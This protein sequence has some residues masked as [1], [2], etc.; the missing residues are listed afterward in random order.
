MPVDVGLPIRKIDEQ[1]F[2]RID[3]RVTGEAFKIH[4]ELGRF[5]NEKNCQ[6]ALH[7]RVME[8]DLSFAR[9]VRI[10]VSLEDFSKDYFLDFLINHAVVV[11]TKVVANVSNKH[12]AQVLN[13]LYLCDVQ[14][15]TL[16]SFGSEKVEHQFVSTSLTTAKR[17]LAMLSKAAFRP[18]SARCSELPDWVRRMISEWGA[19]LDTNLYKD[20]LTHFFGG[21]KRVCQTVD[22]ELDGK[23]IGS[24]PVRLIADGI[25]VSVTSSVHQPEIVREH[26]RRF[27]SHRPLKAIHWINFDRLDVRI[28]AIER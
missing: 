5:V 11:E 25:A 20:A 18:R 7:Q 19:C 14:H 9:E 2:H 26:Q 22:V 3:H 28:E 23:V 12:V 24:Q 4:N 16:L 15:G 10:T 21:D 6:S 1:S 8:T 27:L 13:Y 17:K